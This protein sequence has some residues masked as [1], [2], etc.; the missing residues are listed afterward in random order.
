[1]ELEDLIPAKPEFTLAKT[2][3]TYK[4]RTVNLTDQVWIKN[5]YGSEDSF[6]TVIK[7]NDVEKTLPLVYRL[8][9][10]KSDFM[11]SQEMIVD[12]DGKELEATITGPVKLLRAISGMEEYAKVM[13]AMAKSIMLSNPMIDKVI[14]EHVKKNLIGLK[15]STSSHQNMG[16]RKKKSAN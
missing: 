12:D 7:E 16:G 5:K 8:L 1:M 11:A 2:G 10:D 3:K 14:K 13:G 15:S 4:L 9:E 6:Q